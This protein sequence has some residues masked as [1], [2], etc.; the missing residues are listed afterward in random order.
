MISETE[1]VAAARSGDRTAFEAMIE[2]Y[3]R[4]LKA[5][6]YRMSGSMHDAEDLLQESLLKA[7]RGIGHFESRSSLRTWLYKV[8]TSA[9]LDA[10]DQRKTRS[11][12]VGLGGA[13]TEPGSA[14][15]P[16]P[17]N[18]WVEPC[19]EDLLLDAA[20]SPEAR[21]SARESVALAFLAALQLLPAKQRAV[22]VLRDV[23]GW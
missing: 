6:C 13:P 14:I 12:P 18:L 1:A 20:R 11:L 10:V 5:H 7:W 22:L 16:K 4:E 15:S 9:C 21:Y 2:P 3:R 19:P 23:L 8:T 17:E